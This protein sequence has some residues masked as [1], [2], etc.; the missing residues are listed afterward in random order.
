MSILNEIPIQTGDIEVNGSI[1][2]VEQEPV[3][4]NGTVKELIVFGYEYNRKKFNRIIEATGFVEDLKQFS[5]GK[6]T[7]VG[8]RGVNLSGG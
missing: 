8:E 1:S 6:E 2:Y 5:N 7:E 4:F 3:V